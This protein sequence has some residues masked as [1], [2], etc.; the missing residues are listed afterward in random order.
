M[1]GFGTD[2][3]LFWQF[4][5]PSPRVPQRELFGGELAELLNHKHPLFLLANRIDWASFD[6]RIAA[7]YTQDL[8]RPGLTTRMM[9]GLLYL[10]HAFD[11][12]DESLLAR[13]VENPYWQ[14]FC[15]CEY[16]QHDLPI[17][18]SSLSRWR[19]R[20]GAEGLEQLL[21]ATIQTAVQLKAVKPAELQVVNIDTTVQEKAIA[22][23]TDAR[24]YHKMRLALVRR[25]RELHLPL[26]QTYVRVGKRCL[27]QQGRYAHARQY[28]RAAKLTRK[29]HTM[30]GRV[31]RDIQRKAPQNAGEISDETLRTLCARAER[32]LAQTRTSKDKLYSVHAP[33]VE[34]IAKGKI[35]KKYEFGCKVSLTTTSRSN[36]IIGARACHGNPYDGHTLKEAVAQTKQLTGLEPQ[37]VN[38]DQGYRKHDY[39]GSAAVHVIGRIGKTLSRAMRR[40]FKRRAAIEP[41][42]GHLKS[43]NRLCRNP[44]RR[45][46]GDQINVLLAAA[47][48]NLRKLLR[49]LA[50]SCCC[51]PLGKLRCLLSR[52]LEFLDAQKIARTTPWQE[53]TARACAA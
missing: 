50:G 36:W 40:M 31:L 17:D 25:A 19:Q 24:L 14:Y 47:G 42:I 13:W 34:C 29:L 10:K 1:P 49:W 18:P 7:L 37:H 39:I 43:D 44:L 8:G 53:S 4:M 2:D 35:H 22:F 23:P 3:L 33:E 20:V 27:A 6:A 11:E 12:S 26:R 48:Y 32:L 45:T 21:Q 41:I 30:L 46:S 5:Q 16:L 52:L 51:A 15:G 28:R 38:V 9:V